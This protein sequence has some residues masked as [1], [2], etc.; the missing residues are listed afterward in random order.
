MLYT[1]HEV[2]KFLLKQ[3]S[4]QTNNPLA[5]G[6][7]KVILDYQFIKVLCLFCNCFSEVSH[8][9]FGGNKLSPSQTDENHCSKNFKQNT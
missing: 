1:F 8:F 4:K 6:F 3:M 7:T 2:F 5:T 9:L